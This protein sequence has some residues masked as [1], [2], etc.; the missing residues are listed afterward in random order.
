MAADDVL[1]LADARLACSLGELAAQLRVRI[2][3]RRSL[4]R[5][6]PWLDE[7]GLG[8]VTAAWLNHDPL[9]ARLALQ[10]GAFVL[11]KVKAAG[12]CLR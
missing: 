7:R 5:S 10:V 9:I 6:L 11:I 2:R 8:A 3:E 4:V 12:V 1:S